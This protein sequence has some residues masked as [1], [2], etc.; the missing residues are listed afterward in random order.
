M[1]SGAG[2]FMYLG[3]QDVSIAADD[4]ARL[5][6]AFI[7]RA[8]TVYNDTLVLVSDCYQRP[9]TRVPF[10]GAGREP[11][12]ARMIF[13]DTTMAFGSVF[14][15]DNKVLFAKV[16]NTGTIPLTVSQV[17]DPAAPFTYLSASSFNVRAGDS[18]MLLVQFAPTAQ[19]SYSDSI[20]FT[21]NS[22]PQNLVV[23][24]L[25]GDGILLVHADVLK[26]NIPKEY[27]L[28]S[29]TPNPFN[30]SASIDFA[31]PALKSGA[32]LEISIYSRTGGL[33]KRL[34]H[35]SKEPGFHKIVWDGRDYAGRI[36][37]GG[38]YV[39]SMK[40]RGFKATRK[41]LVVR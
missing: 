5:D 20:V 35:G 24:Y 15:N 3:I 4:S 1:T 36:V 9:T 30:M 21:T 8:V 31:V 7:P 32:A 23:M 11:T 39:C 38:I 13:E 17:N 25:Q 40:G 19:G 14:L 18:T 34:M 37:P 12:V 22:Y 29:I 26:D 28:G 33:V 6:V 27:R 10:N 16:L 2:D 41:I